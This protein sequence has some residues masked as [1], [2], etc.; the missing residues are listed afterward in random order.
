VESEK[1]E[2]FWLEKRIQW[3]LD[4]Y[5][6]DAPDVSVTAVTPKSQKKSFFAPTVSVH[7]QHI[8]REEVWQKNRMK[9]VWCE[10]RK[11]DKI[12]Q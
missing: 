8:A 9:C 10:W 7:Q 1:S 11:R 6:K 2:M 3:L 4:L 5:S 12:S